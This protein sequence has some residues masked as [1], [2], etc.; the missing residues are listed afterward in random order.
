MKKLFSLF[1]IWQ[2]V[3]LN[4]GAQDIIYPKE[5]QPVKAKILEIDR[6]AVRYHRYDWLDGPEHHFNTKDVDSLV[7][8]N[9]TVRKFQFTQTD[10]RPRP[11]KPV[12][13]KRKNFGP[14]REFYKLSPNIISVG[15]GYLAQLEEFVKN[16]PHAF[17]SYERTVSDNRFGLKA[18]AY[19]GNYGVVAATLAGKRYFTNYR[20]VTPYL[21]IGYDLMLARSYK[22]RHHKGSILYLNGGANF[23]INRSWLIIADMNAGSVIGLPEREYD[24]LGFIDYLRFKPGLGVGFRF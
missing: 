15:F 14:N 24:N 22:G 9:G 17:V 16:V 8:E 20:R 19:F 1:L 21:G 7:F 23:H 18:G 10:G 13:G 4:V 5:R 2:F 12:L 6:G 3:W 11:P